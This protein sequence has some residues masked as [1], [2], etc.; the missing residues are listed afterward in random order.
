M[1]LQTWGLV[2]LRFAWEKNLITPDAEKCDRSFMKF[3][4]KGG[5]LHANMNIQICD[6][7]VWELSCRMGIVTGNYPT[8]QEFIQTCYTWQA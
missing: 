3:Q 4:Q 2:P 6:K 8:R 1:F 5:V 7:E